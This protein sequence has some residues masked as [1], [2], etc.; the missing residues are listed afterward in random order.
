LPELA[1]S[2]V[3]ALRRH[4]AISLGNILGSNLYN[5]LAILGVSSLLAPVPIAP[6]IARV[7]MWVMAG[8]AAFL[9][10]A[11][12]SGRVG[13]GLGAVMIAG[14]AA[15]VARLVVSAV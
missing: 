7:E 11:L 1:T 5:I 10:P 8:F 9:L 2:V 6:E 4:S 13:R 12:A 15:Y 3:A 14:Y